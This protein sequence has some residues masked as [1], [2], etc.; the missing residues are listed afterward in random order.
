MA[1]RAVRES[2]D[3]DRKEMVQALIDA[4]N[5]FPEMA[6]DIAKVFLLADAVAIKQD[7]VEI[8][9]EKLELEKRKYDDAIRI[10]LIDLA[11]AAGVVPANGGKVIESN[12]VK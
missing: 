11:L 9:R 1:G 10:K 8:K 6:V 7:E 12:P 4:R 3:Y 2:W 5:M